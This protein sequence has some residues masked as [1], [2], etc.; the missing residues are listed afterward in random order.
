[1]GQYVFNP[2]GL[3]TSSSVD[4]QLDISEQTN[5]II[6]VLKYFGVI[7]NDPTIVQVAAKEIQE[8]SINE[9]S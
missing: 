2:V 7:I 6:N 4:F 5:L 8:T 9:K 1:L 3:G